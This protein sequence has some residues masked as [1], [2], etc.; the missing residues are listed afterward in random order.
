MA[1]HDTSKCRCVECEAVRRLRDQFAMAALTLFAHY[2]PDEQRHKA[3]A[4]EAY[5]YADALLKARN[6]DPQ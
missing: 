2:Q 3:V 6:D 5:L 4:K 1:K